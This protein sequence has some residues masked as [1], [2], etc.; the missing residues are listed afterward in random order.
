MDASRC[1]LTWCSMLFL[2]ALEV[3]FSHT[4]SSTSYSSLI[5]VLLC[6]TLEQ[7]KRHHQLKDRRRLAMEARLQKVKARRAKRLGVELTEEGEL[8]AEAELK[9]E[10]AE[11][12]SAEID[13]AEL[14]ARTADEIAESRRLEEQRREAATLEWE[15]GLKDRSSE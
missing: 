10:I 11:R 7:R 4:P 13:D 9:Q 12:K 6:Q 14:A 15:R 1:R 2:Y 8:D 5:V 3:A